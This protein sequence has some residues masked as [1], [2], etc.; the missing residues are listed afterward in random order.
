MNP[1]ST[2]RTITCDWGRTALFESTTLP[3]KLAVVYCAYAGE[4]H[5][6]KT[7]VTIDQDVGDRIVF[8]LS[9]GFGFR[10]PHHVPGA[11]RSILHEFRRR[12]RDRAASRSRGRSWSEDAAGCL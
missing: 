12:T 5:T 3:P 7:P 11:R 2:L 10:E 8:L 4:I 1:V 9:G 6:T